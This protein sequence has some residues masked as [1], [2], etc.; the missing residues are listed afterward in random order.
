VRYDGS[1]PVLVRILT[2]ALCA[3]G[4]IGAVTSFLLIRGG[5]PWPMPD[6][7]YRFLAGAAVA[8]AVGSAI[9]L[10]RR[11]WAE[12]ELLLATVALY[13]VPL[14]I[15]MLVQPGPVDWTQPVA[16]SFVGLVVPALAISIGALWVNRRVLAGAEPDPLPGRLRGLLG[17][18]AVLG[19]VVGLLVFAVPR[20]AG[21]VWPWAELGPWKAL[22]SR[23]LA[24]MLLTI[25]G[26]AALVA[27][28]NR[29]AMADVFLPML[30]SYC[31]VAGAGL[32]IHAV[33]TPAMRTEDL[34]YVAIFAILAV[35]TF[36]LYVPQRIAGYRQQP[37]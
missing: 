37:A 35:S 19:G 10:T 4:A 24:S 6:L 14:G 33:N 34:I 36:S 26:A 1:V 27:W 8:Y 11:G 30:W 22:D 16:W 5:W 25:G 15:A 23:L 13:G 9:T 28:R 29:Q 12:S 31:V 3:G 21:F 32:V 7:A 20:E 18:I 17:V 2:V